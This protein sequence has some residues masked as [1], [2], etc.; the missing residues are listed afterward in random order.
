MC[1]SRF[2]CL[3]RSR[4]GFQLFDLSFF[5]DTNKLSGPRLQTWPSPPG[6]KTFDQK[7]YDDK[8]SNKEPSTEEPS[9]EETAQQGVA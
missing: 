5:W 7:A 3:S 9:S 2:W 6:D 8:S 1:S 4:D